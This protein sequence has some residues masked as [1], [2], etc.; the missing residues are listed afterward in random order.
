MNGANF[1]TT[2]SPHIKA[3]IRYATENNFTH[4]KLYG[5]AKCLLR[6]E[7]ARALADV[8]D[9]LAKKGFRLKVWDCYRPLS[10]QKVLWSLVPDER[11]V[12]NPAQGSR[13]NRGAAVDLTLVDKKGRELPMPTAFDDFTDKAHRDSTD[14]SPEALRNRA[15]LEEV[16]TRH[17][18]DGLPTEWWHFD[19]RGWEKYELLDVPL[20]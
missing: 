10:V 7:A 9:S 3:E 12:A 16:M 5:A 19:F 15:L 13:H 17:G 6:P 2:I 18:F 1:L 8:A 20:K 14:A 11:Y 4:K